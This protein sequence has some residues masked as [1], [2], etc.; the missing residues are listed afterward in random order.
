TEYLH[1][2]KERWSHVHPLLIGEKTGFQVDVTIKLQLAGPPLDQFCT[3]GMRSVDRHE[4]AVVNAGAHQRQFG[5][6]LAVLRQRRVEVRRQYSEAALAEGSHDVAQRAQY[7]DVGIQI[8]Q[9]SLWMAQPQPF[10]HVRLDR[11]VQFHDVVAE[12]ERVERRQAELVDRDRLEE[13]RIQRW[14]ARTFVGEAQIA[15]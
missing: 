9:A 2:R 10:E 8:H 14:I 5:R 7:V 11:R 6:K 4:T 15:L 12:H 1:A 13:F 3:P